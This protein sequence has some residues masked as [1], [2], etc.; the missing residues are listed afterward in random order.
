[1]TASAGGSLRSVSS[2]V[3]PTTLAPGATS[4]LKIFPGYLIFFYYGREG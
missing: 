2:S 4:F 3:N 1:M